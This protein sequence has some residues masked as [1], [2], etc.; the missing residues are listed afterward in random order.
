VAISVKPFAIGLRIEHEQN[1][2]DKL[3]YGSYHGHP[4]LGAADYHLAWRDDICGRGVYT[5]CMCPGGY[6]VNA[7]SE[8]YGIATNGMSFAARNSG[9]ANSAIVATVN[10]NDYGS[11]PLNALKWQEHWERLA[12]SA[13]GGDHSLP[14]QMAEDFLQQRIGMIDADFQPL[15]PGIKAADLHTC[16]PKPVTESISRA[17][18]N[19]QRQM[20]GFI[21]APAVLAGIETRTS[22]PLRI[23]RDIDLQSINRKGLYPI[24]E[25]A[26]YAGGI[27]SSAIDGIKAAQAI[28]KKYDQPIHDF[29]VEIK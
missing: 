10:Q 4:A 2:I 29:P 11:D 3:Q 27:V 23:E 7:A 1:F 13:G 22:A 16:L 5:F 9:R 6:I 21:K 28:I 18:D 17:L 15:A 19:W 14:C 20:S 25:G 24:G 12:F 8:A 26:G